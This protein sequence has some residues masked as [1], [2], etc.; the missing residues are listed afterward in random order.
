MAPKTQKDKIHL[1]VVRDSRNPILIEPADASKECLESCI[2]TYG[3]QSASG[4]FNP[5]H[6]VYKDILG[7][8]QVLKFAQLGVKPVCGFKTPDLAF[9]TALRA[10]QEDMAAANF[11]LVRF[12]ADPMSLKCLISTL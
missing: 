10:S 2:V 8:Y 4:D 6:V 5:Y 11:A 9:S 12:G 3:S 7:T 1:L